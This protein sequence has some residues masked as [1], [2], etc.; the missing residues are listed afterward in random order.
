MGWRDLLSAAGETVVAP[1][2]GG[3]TLHLIARSFQIRGALAE[4]AGWYRFEVDGRS[5][6]FAGTAEPKVSQLRFRVEGYLVGDRLVPDDVSVQ[7]DV[8]RL[9]A[10]TQRVFLV[11]SGL[12]RFA[13]VSAGRV[14]ERGDL[15]FAEELFPL[16]PE[17]EV[18]DA[19]GR[20]SQSLMDVSGVAPAL[21]AAFRIECFRRDAAQR[22]RA[23]AEQAKQRQTLVDELG[24]GVTRRARAV[25]DFEGAARAALAVSGA[26]YLDH[27][28]SHERDEVVV[29]F[30]IGTQAFE[31]ICHAR[32]LRVIDA[33]V[34]LTDDDTGL[35]GDEFFTL[36]SL[37]GVIKQAQREDVLVVFRHVAG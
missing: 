34:C 14:C 20:R 21:D 10:S 6:R 28:S 17:L 7:L 30:R 35:R 19:L 31:C 11:P 25:Y 18:Q 22:R 26:T 27:R 5:A 29:R 9:A 4:T 2:T 37:P 33:G 24:S 12:Q 32:T 23:R 13:R 16:G 8:R 3:R 15:V 36:E 1:W